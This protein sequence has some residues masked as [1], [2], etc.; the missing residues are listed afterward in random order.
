MII[1]EIRSIYLNI[2]EQN[3]NQHKVICWNKNQAIQQNMG[4]KF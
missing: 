4:N 3:M 1:T 2:I